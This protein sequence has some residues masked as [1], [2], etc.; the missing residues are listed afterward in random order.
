MRIAI[1]GD[2]STWNFNDRKN[3]SIPM[4]IKKEISS[5]DVFIFNLEGPIIERNQMADGPYNNKI[6]S[7]LLSVINKKQ[8]AVHNDTW[9]LDILDMCEKNVACL[10]NNHILDGGK[11]GI[12]STIEKISN[13]GFLHL[14]A[15]TN[16]KQAS[17]PLIIKDERANISIVNYNYVG[18]RVMGKYFNIFGADRNSAGANYKN[19]TKVNKE[20]KKLDSDSDYTIAICHIG[21]ELSSTISKK[22]EE[23]LERIPADIVIAHHPHV[24][25]EIDLNNV[26]TCGDFFFRNPSLPDKRES[27]ILLDEID[28]ETKK[29]TFSLK[30]G[31]PIY[32]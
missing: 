19:I 10:S 12:E 18:W 25:I 27:N 15:G 26:Y 8:P 4:D 23:I 17:S 30:N 14:G 3:I 21:S 7:S 5:S 6:I 16:I 9:I 22:Q 2:C 20:M 13:N 29:K 32:E 1:A 31:S 24:P 28:G 11:K